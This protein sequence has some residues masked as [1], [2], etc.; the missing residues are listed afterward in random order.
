M[1]SI[2]GT[3]CTL[4]TAWERE[5]DGKATAGHED[6]E[7]ASSLFLLRISPKAI[8]ITT[9]FSKNLSSENGRSGKENHVRYQRKKLGSNPIT[10]LVCPC[11]GHAA[12]LGLEKGQAGKGFTSVE[13]R[14]SLGQAPWTPGAALRA[15]APGA[16][17]SPAPA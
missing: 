9:H 3:A 8:A 11:Q 10:S 14:V 5:S 15:W 6:Q 13:T 2:W 7:P 12:S 1:L 17:A 4:L 16:T